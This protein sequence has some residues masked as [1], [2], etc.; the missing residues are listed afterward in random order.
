VL[1]AILTL[2]GTGI[3]QAKL[4]PPVDTKYVEV[5]FKKSELVNATDAFVVAILAEKPSQELLDQH[6]KAVVASLLE[7]EA[8][9]GTAKEIYLAHDKMQLAIDDYMQNNGYD[10]LNQVAQAL[11]AYSRYFTETLI[12]Q[13]DL[14][15]QSKPSY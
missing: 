5:E 9:F 1:L 14:S 6:F 4:F 12:A 11:N 2:I 7:Y 10:P 8:S 3:V 13:T 15:S